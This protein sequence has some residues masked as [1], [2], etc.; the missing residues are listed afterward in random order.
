MRWKFFMEFFGVGFCKQVFHGLNPMA[1]GVAISWVVSCLCRVEKNI[2]Y[3]MVVSGQSV[4]I[5]TNL[6]FSDSHPVH[7]IATKCSLLWRTFKSSHST[8]YSGD[9][10]TATKEVSLK[11]KMVLSF[12]GGHTTGTALKKF[13]WK[14]AAVRRQPLTWQKKFWIRN[15]SPPLREI[16]IFFLKGNYNGG[17]W[18][19]LLYVVHTGSLRK[20]KK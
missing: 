20:A 12:S 10:E 14:I 7:L 4:Y 2:F 5:T 6:T 3:K 18:Q 16:F 9:Q 19:Q 11:R 13:F 15:I 1:L 17:P 8:T